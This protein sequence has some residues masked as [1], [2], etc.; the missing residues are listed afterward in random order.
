MTAFAT[1][2]AELPAEI[3][4]FPLERALLLPGG[5]L[6]LNIFEPRYL[7]M[8][9][10]AL[11][12]L[13]LFGMMLPDPALPPGP[14]GPG[15]FKVGCLGRIISFA[16]TE[17]GRMLV[18]LQ[19]LI[20]FRIQRE[21]PLE[22]PYRR[23][24]VDYASFQADL[25][26]PPEGVVDREAL[27]AALREYFAA[28]RLQAN[29][30]GIDQMSDATLVTNLSMICPF[31]AAEQQALLEAPDLA[32]RASMLTTLMRMEAASDLEPPALPS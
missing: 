6:P 15:L 13:R 24:L 10:A 32:S 12:H 20:R 11:A 18:T 5:R 16:E 8:T 7:A 17:D 22:R 25:A 29:W 9:E 4:F 2:F 23:A 31:G 1:P 27:L 30:Q 3:P 14:N 19:G 21:L 28:R 26:P